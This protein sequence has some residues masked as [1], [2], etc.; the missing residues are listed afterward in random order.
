MSKLVKF[1]YLNS[2]NILG[3]FRDVY[4]L[5]K[6]KNIWSIM[7]RLYVNVRSLLS[8]SFILLKAEVKI[9]ICNFYFSF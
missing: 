1:N 3:V 6:K 7:E 4:Y 5:Y 9:I 8:I 2:L